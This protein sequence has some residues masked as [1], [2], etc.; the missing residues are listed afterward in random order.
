M[1]QQTNL[2]SPEEEPAITTQQCGGWARVPLCCDVGWILSVKKLQVP[3]LEGQC[4]L[5]TW[6]RLANWKAAAESVNVN[7]SDR[8]GHWEFSPRVAFWD[9][10]TKMG[11][12][13]QDG[14]SPKSSDL[15][16]YPRNKLAGHGVILSVLGR[17]R[18]QDGPQLTTVHHKPRLAFFFSISV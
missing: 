11:A 4:T 12:S 14:T 16:I 7:S 18:R 3:V 1:F 10:A 6:D 8:P 2:E 5:N 13:L 9:C 15:K 17:S